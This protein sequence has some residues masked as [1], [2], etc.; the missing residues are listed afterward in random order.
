MTAPL[1]TTGPLHLPEAAKPSAPNR[2][3]VP[4]PK[5]DRERLRAAVREY[6]ATHRPVPPFTVDELDLHSGRV[7]NSTGADEK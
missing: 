4:Q 6:V 2:D 5:A 3:Q 7:L 1:E